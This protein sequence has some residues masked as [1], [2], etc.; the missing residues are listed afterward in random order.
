MKK[1]RLGSVILFKSNSVFVFVPTMLLGNKSLLVA[2]RG[3][4]SLK[5]TLQSGD[6][7][8]GREC[9]MQL[10]KSGAHHARSIASLRASQHVGMSITR[11]ADEHKTGHYCDLG[12][13]NRSRNSKLHRQFIE[14]VSFSEIQDGKSKSCR[15]PQ[16]KL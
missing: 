10:W 6:L 2:K 3:M 1:Y 16:K 5:S 15:N 11:L 8:A 4:S 9:L 13:S 7:L 14:A 12:H